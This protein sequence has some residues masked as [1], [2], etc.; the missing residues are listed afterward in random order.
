MRKLVVILCSL[1]CTMQVAAQ[2]VDAVVLQ[3]TTEIDCRDMRHMRTTYHRMYR[4]DNE[5]ARDFAD[6]GTAC[7]KWEKLT[8]FSCVVT[9]AKGKEVRK[10]K[11]GDLNRSDLNLTNFADDYYTFTLDYTP[12]SYPVTIE[13]KWTKEANNGC[14]G[15]PT[16]APVEAYN[17]RVEH[18]SYLLTAPAEMS[19]RYL[20]LNTSATVSQSTL[21]DGRVRYEAHMDNLPAIDSEPYSPPA[22][23]ILPRILWAPSK[24]EFHGVPG[25]MSSWQSFGQWCQRLRDGRQELADDFRAQLHAMTDTCSSDR[26]KVEVIYHYLAETTRY[27]SIQLGIGGWQPFAASDVCRTGFGDCKGLSNYLCAMLHE[28]GVP[29]NYVTIYNNRPRLV[30]NFPCSQFNHAIAQVPLP[31]DTLWLEC[32]SAAH[33]PLGHVHDGIAGNDALLCDDAGGHLVK[34]PDYAPEQ[35]LSV[36]TAHVTLQPDGSASINI[37]MRYERRQ[38]DDLMPLTMRTEQQRRDVMLKGINLSTVTL[39]DF[40]F[41]EHKSSYATPHI[42]VTMQL[43]NRKM[44]NIT[45]ARMFVP[46]DFF[47]TLTVPRAL[48][49]RVQSVDIDYGYLDIDTVVVAIPQGYEVE[50]LPKAVSEVTPLGE[51]SQTFEVSGDMVTIITRHLMRNGRYPASEYATLRSLKSA[52][53]KA[54]DQRIVLRRK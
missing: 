45:G 9:D 2:T 18:A 53:K 16:F 40:I 12:P 24:F 6:W 51:L 26:S 1:V 39:K 34:L 19:C 33:V 50:A 44:A 13:F 27:V 52:V 5:R 7:S 46:A 41:T 31:G 28:V 29:A 25:D 15:F 54:Y 43:E 48:Q 38:Y 36:N 47:H 37:S 11:K 32:T 42:D 49:Q 14:F 3:S 35:N 22:R 17:T 23:E 10:F 30:T 4:L 20:C 8:D 21:S